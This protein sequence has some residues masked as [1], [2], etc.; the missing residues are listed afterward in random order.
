MRFD[1]SG[2]L[3]KHW[4]L[5]PLAVQR[6]DNPNWSVEYADQYHSSYEVLRGVYVR[7]DEDAGPAGQPLGSQYVVFCRPD[8]AEALYVHPRRVGWTAR[9]RQAAEGLARKALGS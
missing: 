4:P 7:F 3:A 5:A 9:I 6:W 2:M 1:P 8:R